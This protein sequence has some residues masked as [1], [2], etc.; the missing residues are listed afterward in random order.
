MSQPILHIEDL[1]VSY[2]PIKALKGVNIA[3]QPGEIVALLGANGAGKTTLLRTI[4]GLYTPDGGKIYFENE[5]ITNKDPTFIVRK[6]VIHVPEHRQVFGTLTVL[7][8]LYLGAYH[9][10]RR[11]EKRKIME[12]LEKI[13]SLFPILKERKDQLAG[14]LSGGQQQMLAIARGVMAKPKLILLDEPTLGLAPIVAK[15]VLNMIRELN[16]TFGT[17]VLLIEQNVFASL[18][19]AHRGYVI[20]NGNIVKEGTAYQLLQDEGVK[21]AYLGHAVN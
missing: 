15:E 11:S 7:D 18:K 14:T 5:D 13:F 19:I 8:N 6:K 9:H 17:T 10:Y 21:E 12:D 2:G 3:V 4:S 20:A 1:H 16:R